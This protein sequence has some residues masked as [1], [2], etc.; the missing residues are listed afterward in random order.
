MSFQT[1]ALQLAELDQQICREFFAANTCK[2]GRLLNEY[3]KLRKSLKIQMLD[4]PVVSIKDRKARK[5]IQ[6]IA[7]SDGL[8]SDIVIEQLLKLSNSKS[9]TE[10]FEAIDFD[11]FSSDLFYSWYSHYEYIEALIKMRPLILQCNPSESVKRLVNQ[12]RRCYAFQQYDAAYGLCRTLLE[13]GVYDICR[14]YKLVPEQGDHPLPIE[15][16]KW[17]KLNKKVS[18]GLVREKLRDL[19]RRLGTV[20]HAGRSVTSEEALEAFKETLLVIER[21]YD[22]H[23]T[24]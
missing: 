6:N 9:I 4:E 21:L 7:S 20:L 23:E 17:D 3:T 19:Y 2:L 8:P 18:S 22:R 1:D 14:R 24:P 12:V 15:K 10:E 13:A 16:Y 5:V 11:E